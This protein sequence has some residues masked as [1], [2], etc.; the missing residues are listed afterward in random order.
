[1]YNILNYYRK[2][3]PKEADMAYLIT[4]KCIGCTLCAKNCPM[5]AISGELKGKH[6]IDVKRC[7]E[8]GVCGSLCAT[9]AILDPNGNPC[10]KIS[11]ADR[12]VPVIDSSK[13]CGCSLCIETC[14]KN[15]LSLC[16]PKFKGDIAI[17]AA[18][19][20]VKKCVGCGMCAK[21][22]P[23]GAIKMIKRSEAQA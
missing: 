18:L 11:P 6:S 2:V 5:Y 3:F 19:P 12:P 7:V 13:C 4:D 23:Q 17:I 16:A 21:I 14:G 15:A 10:E 1:M 8:C 20:D 22:C 9:G